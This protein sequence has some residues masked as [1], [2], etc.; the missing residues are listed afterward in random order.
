MAV[1]LRST[2]RSLAPYLAPYRRGIALGFAALVCKV[3]AATAVPFIL[4]DGF[5][6]LLAGFDFAKLAG[7]AGLLLGASVLRGF[8]QYYMRL[9]LVSISRDIEFNLRNDIFSHLVR[10]HAGFFQTMRTGDIMA[11]ATNDLNQVRMMLGPGVMYWL[12]TVLTALLSMSVMFSVDWKLTLIALIPAPLVSFAVV[13]FGQRIHQR[14][15][16]IQ[17]QFSDISSR[18]QENL[19]GAR[20]VR[21]YAQE[22][23]EVEQFAALNRDYIQA[24][25]GLVRDTGMFYPVL[26]ALVGLTFLLV[27]WAGGWRLAQGQITLGGFVM[28]QSY[29]GL[30]IWPMIAFGW[31]IN[32]TQRGTASLKRIQ[33]I[34]GAVPAISAPA[35]PASLPEPVRGAIR[36][37]N[38]TVSFGEVRA[39]DDVTLEIPAGA[40]V[41]IVGH[42][43]AGKSTLLQLLA[44]LADPTTGRVLLDGIDLREVAPETIR[45]QIGFVPQ[46]TFLF[47]T[48]L[49]Q[50]IRLGAPETTLEEVKAASEKAGLASDVAGFPD[51]YETEIGERGIT[52]S[53]GQKQRTAIARALLRD[54]AVLILDDALSA[55]D[56]VTEEK[57]LRQLAHVVKGR[58]AIFVSHRVSTVKDCDCI[59]VLAQGRLIEKGTHEELLSKGGYYADLHQ[60]QLLE[61][62]LDQVA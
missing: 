50:N 22:E 35:Q 23:A 1:S 55:V 48:S 52:L 25:M 60:K 32:L 36:L 53:G 19:S 16:V 56:T 18:V 3:A 57:I 61:E 20:I 6:S 2:V 14:F 30:L 58:T 38:V 21:A 34:L 45:R 8:C 59:F 43:G 37:E 62:E 40:T 10:L 4:R 24:N 51:G 29:M 28:F 12:E 54:P 9:K 7:F 31:V 47:S 27:L 46:E 5:D 49:A 42:T 15:E 11:R 39:L 13:Y 17:E 26:Q 33:E 41:A 44:R